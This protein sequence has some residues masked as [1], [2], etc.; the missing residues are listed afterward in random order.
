MAKEMLQQA[1]VDDNAKTVSENISDIEHKKDGQFTSEVNS[2]S[3]RTLGLDS[4]I[5]TVR[6]KEL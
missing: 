2:G 6:K 5:T 1:I 3:Q 4:D